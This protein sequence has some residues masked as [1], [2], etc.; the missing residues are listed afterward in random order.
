MNS[1]IRR[2]RRRVTVCETSRSEPFL[3]V[4][5]PKQKCSDVKMYHVY[6]INETFGSRKIMTI[7]FADVCTDKTAVKRAVVDGAL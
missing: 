5:E 2:S 3:F 4:T 7:I 6:R 1:E